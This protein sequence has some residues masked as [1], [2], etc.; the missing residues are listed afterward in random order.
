M[1]RKP[2]RLV[3]AKMASMVNYYYTSQFLGGGVIFYLLPLLVNSLNSCQIS[4]AAKKGGLFR[5]CFLFIFLYLFLA[6]YLNIY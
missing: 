6:I 5:C 3:A 2:V 1:N 4:L